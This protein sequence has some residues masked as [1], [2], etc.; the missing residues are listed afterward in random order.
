[1][2][3][4]DKIISINVSKKYK[5][6]HIKSESNTSIVLSYCEIVFRVISLSLCQLYY[7]NQESPRFNPRVLYHT[8]SCQEL[9]KTTH[10]YHQIRQNHIRL[11]KD[12]YSIWKNRNHLT[13]TLHLNLLTAQHTHTSVLGT[14]EEGQ[15][16]RKLIIYLLIMIIGG[17]WNI[18]GKH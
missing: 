11:T 8:I 7:F 12:L 16:H 17:L 9:Q 15:L 10:C 3:K 5:T 4:K 1:M 13:L 18:H 6:W 2:P 14:T